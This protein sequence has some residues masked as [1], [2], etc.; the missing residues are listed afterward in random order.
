MSGI[1]NFFL[2]IQCAVKGSSFKEGGFSKDDWSECF[3]MAQEQS[4]LG[5]LF[6]VVQK[7]MY[8]ENDERLEPVFSEWLGATWQ[9]QEQN[10]HV[11]QQA[12]MLKRIVEE[13]GFNGCVL[14]GQGVAQLYPDPLLRQSGDID[15]WIDGDR[16]SFLEKSRNSYISISNV[17]YVHS[18]MA[19]FVDTKVEI[20]FRPSWM[21]N[22]FHNY[23]LQKFFK[24][25]KDS[26]MNHYASEVNFSYPTISFNLVYSLIHINRHIFEEGIG[27]RQMMDYYF[28]LIH[29]NI[30]ERLNAYNFLKRLNLQRFAGAVMYVMVKVFDIENGFLLCKPNFKEGKFL[31]DEILAGGNFG[32]YDSRNKWFEKGHRIEKNLFNAKRNLRYLKHY[33]SEVVWIPFWKLWHWCWRKRKGYL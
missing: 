17:D 32:F 15:F 16:D 14:K 7:Y 2:L 4:L 12:E 5:V 27:L 28:I 24:K 9:I 21:Y 11:N 30:E 20:H 26:Q 22:P 8:G 1:K 19:F 13:W 29:S 33:P 25:H 3:G 23:R 10:K 18:G 31:L 6:P